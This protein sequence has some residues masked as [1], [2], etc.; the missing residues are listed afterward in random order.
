VNRGLQKFESFYNRKTPLPKIGQLS[1]MRNIVSEIINPPSRGELG[2]QNLRNI[3]ILINSSYRIPLICFSKAMYKVISEVK[4]DTM[5][6]TMLLYGG[7]R[8]GGES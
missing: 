6:D 1:T 7:G 8:G 2:A 4:R 5:L 3:R